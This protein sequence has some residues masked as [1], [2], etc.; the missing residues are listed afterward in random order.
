MA[1]CVSIILPAHNASATI[2]AAIGSVLAQTYSHWELLIIEN[3]STDNTWEKCRQFEDSRIV[4][5][6]APHAGLSH[7]RNMGLNRATGSYVCFLDADDLLPSNSLACRVR[8]M[9]AD[10]QITFCDG[11]VEKRSQDLSDL[12]T[13][14]VPEQPND[15]G[16]EMHKINAV[17]FCG[18]TW[19]IRRSMIGALR[20]DEG[21]SHLE[22]RLFFLQLA[23]NGRYAAVA[24]TIYIIRKTRGSL[25]SNHNKLQY[26]YQ[27]FLTLVKQ[28]NTLH[29]EE[30]HEQCYLF[31]RMFFK[32]HLKSG[33]YLAA[34][35]ILF[36]P[37]Y[38]A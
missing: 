25:M 34:M 7:A 14:W 10:P 15:L 6:Q 27:R 32:T 31:K 23:Q 37:V 29:A 9:S 22:D 38:L 13:T 30:L 2:E 3:G 4:L 26:A 12:L 18:V 8:L 5:I 16:R 35:K 24:E 20:F 33:R 1:E 17:C 19:M 36:G 21:W 28:Q 11:R